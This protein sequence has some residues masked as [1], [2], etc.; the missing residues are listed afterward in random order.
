MVMADVMWA[1][2]LVVRA[3]GSVMV[4]RTVVMW[5]PSFFSSH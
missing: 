1:V 3:S 5:A 2:L 4:V